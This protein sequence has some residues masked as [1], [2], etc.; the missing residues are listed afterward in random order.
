MEVENT[1]ASA[2]LPLQ[3]GKLTSTVGGAGMPV[4]SVRSF[5]NPDDYCSSMRDF[6]YELT[7]TGGGD[8]AAEHVRVELHKLLVQRYYSNLPWVAH[9]ETMKGRATFALRADPGPSLLRAG[10]EMQTTNIERLAN[11]HGLYTRSSGTVLWG[12]ISLSVDALAAIDATTAGCDLKPPVDVVTETPV[13][14]AMA[15]LQRLHAAAAHLAKRAPEIIANPEAARGPEHDLAQALVACL[16]SSKCEEDA[17]AKRQHA[18]VM[19]RFHAAITSSGDRP[20]YVSDLC[21]AIGVSDRTLQVCC[22]EHLGMGPQKYLWLRRMQHAHHALALADHAGATVT[23]IATAHGFWELGR[24]AGAY[25]SLYGEVPSATLA[26]APV[27][28]NSQHIIRQ[29]HGDFR[30]LHS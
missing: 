20:V 8:F 11:G 21:S 12:S 10:A 29:C 15:R 9:T 7:V 4:S 13:P 19:R 24:F 6:R 5:S 3:S 23:E 18:L 14:A 16:R 17:V 28:A 25:R 2:G 26:R 27:R 22:Q 30:K 1:V